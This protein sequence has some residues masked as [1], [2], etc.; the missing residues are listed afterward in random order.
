MAGR[1]AS[2]TSKKI[3]DVVGIFKTELNPS[4]NVEFSGEIKQGDPLY[5]QADISLLKS[6]GYRNNYTLQNGITETIQWQK[7][8]T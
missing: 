4:I 1:I 7:T 5:W 6:L 8:Q 3:K 2:G